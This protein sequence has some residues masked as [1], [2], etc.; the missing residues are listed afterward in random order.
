[1]TTKGAIDN[2][3][4]Q[5]ELNKGDPKSKKKKF[6]LVYCLRG[7]STNTRRGNSKY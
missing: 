3:A 2:L 4:K 6:N 5:P 7:S 1:M